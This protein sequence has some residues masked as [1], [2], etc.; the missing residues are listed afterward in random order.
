MNANDRAALVKRVLETVEPIVAAVLE[1]AAVA[2]G[3]PIAGAAAA[4]AAN[5]VESEIARIGAGGE[6]SATL[7][8]EEAEA[9]VIRTLGES[10]DVP[11]QPRPAGPS[12]A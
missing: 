12:A 7:T 11:Q 2:Y 8:V 10:P 5:V 9:T 1:A 6:S 3:G 4:A